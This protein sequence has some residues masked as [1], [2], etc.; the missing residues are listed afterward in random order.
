MLKVITERVPGEPHC[1]RGNWSAVYEGGFYVWHGSWKSENSMYKEDDDP[2]C[3]YRLDML[4]LK[5]EELKM[6]EDKGIDSNHVLYSLS[7][8]SSTQHYNYVYT[9]GGHSMTGW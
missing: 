8:G 1:R 3:I 4:S 9:F 7:C 6:K 5:W 2:T